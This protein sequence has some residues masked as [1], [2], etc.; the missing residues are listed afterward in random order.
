MPP[1]YKISAN[2]AVSLRRGREHAMG[3]FA[4][5]TVPVFG[6]DAINEISQKARKKPGQLRPMP[7]PKNI[8]INQEYRTA[9]LP[10]PSFSVI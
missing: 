4:K 10:P 7:R 8:L 6:N 2:K 1:I 3:V 5:P 9:L